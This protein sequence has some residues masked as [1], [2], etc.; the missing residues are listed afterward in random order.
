MRTSQALSYAVV[1]L[2][3]ASSSS[4]YASVLEET[5]KSFDAD[6][7]YCVKFFQADKDSTTADKRGLAVISTTMARE[8]AGPL[9]DCNA[10][11]TGAVNR[12]DEAARSIAS[13]RLQDAV[14]SLGYT[15]RVADSCEAG[16]S[17]VGVKSQLATEDAEFT[18]EC[19]IAYF[20]T[21]RLYLSQPPKV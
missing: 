9:A 15:L 1:L 13:G 3:L 8:A 21:R 2:L 6:Y 12:F 19:S 17:K 4:S 18:K 20:V 16:F 11:Y 10:A 5:C 14:T 7:D